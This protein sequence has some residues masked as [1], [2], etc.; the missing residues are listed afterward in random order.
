MVKKKSYIKRLNYNL[1]SKR[2]TDSTVSL[3]E[4]EK[5]IPD[6]SIR[7]DIKDEDVGELINR[8]LR[9]QKPDA[10]NTFIRRYWFFDSVSDIASRY[11]FTE[12]KVKSLLYHTR[13]K[14]RDYLMKEGIYL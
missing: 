2:S 5:I 1:A 8:F 9:T 4:L 10:R 14:L 6:N 11:N 3:S 13:N 12:S 7:A